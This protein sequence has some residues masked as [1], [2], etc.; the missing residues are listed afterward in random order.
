M[1]YVDGLLLLASLGVVEYDSTNSSA[2]LVHAIANTRY[3]TSPDRKATSKSVMRSPTSSSP[4]ESR[5]R[6]GGELPNVS[7][8]ARCS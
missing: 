2:D 3:Y 4:I 7:M 5:S 1:D 6:F 8:D